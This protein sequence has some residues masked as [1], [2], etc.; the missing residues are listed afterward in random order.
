MSHIWINGGT[1]QQ[2][3]LGKKKETRSWM[4][5]E[6]KQEWPLSA[7]DSDHHYKI[8]SDNHCSCIFLKKFNSDQ[9]AKLQWRLNAA[10]VYQQRSTESSQ[11]TTNSTQVLNK[12]WSLFVTSHFNNASASR[13]KYEGVNRSKHYYTL[14]L[15]N[16]IWLAWLSESTY[17]YFYLNN[18]RNNAFSSNIYRLINVLVPSCV[19][20]ITAAHSYDSNTLQHL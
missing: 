13:K 5:E 6:S 20:T 3:L 11:S 14:L 19:R 7:S 16:S 12:T 18:S 9:I 8:S 10:A 4:E 17:L 2:R 15:Y 1:K